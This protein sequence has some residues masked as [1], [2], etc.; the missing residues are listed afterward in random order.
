[1]GRSGLARF[2]VEVRGGVHT[3]LSLSIPVGGAR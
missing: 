3:P 1:M 2:T